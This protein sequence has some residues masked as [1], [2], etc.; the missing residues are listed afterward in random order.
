MG[1][2]WCLPIGIQFL[3]CRRFFTLEN[4][5][6]SPYLGSYIYISTYVSS[7]T[8]GVISS[9]SRIS[10]L[11]NT[12]L[13]SSEI[14]VYYSNI[15]SLSCGLGLDSSYPRLSSYKLWWIFASNFTKVSLTSSI[16]NSRLVTLCTV[17]LDIT[18]PVWVSMW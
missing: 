1:F 6:P 3:S 17:D 12:L 16:Y 14:W 11:L 18:F 15:Y 8:S 5:G 7:S 4:L 2:S 10:A 13:K 9:A